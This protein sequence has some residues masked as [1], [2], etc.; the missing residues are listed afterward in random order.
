MNSRTSFDRG[1]WL[2]DSFAMLRRPAKQ[3]RTI[4]ATARYSG[5]GQV[6]DVGGGTG[7]IA[8]YFAEHGSAVTVLD[9]SPEML[10][11]AQARSLD[12]Q[13]G[14]AQDI[15]FA[16]E[17]FELVYSVDA[18]HH[19]T[20]GYESADH[21]QTID[22]CIRELLRV[23]KPNGT[24][25]LVEFNPEQWWGKTVEFLENR[26]CRLGSTF[27]SPSALRGIFAP[28]P[29]HIEITEGGS[30]TYLARIAKD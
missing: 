20:N 17:T 14:A 4:V 5:S 27:S 13:L 16:D 24:L 11:R 22:R 3:Y 10:K 15:P 28:Y 8:R 6:L 9:P 12:T 26:I 25:M 30:A 23:L 21:R 18:F 1:A 2:Y 19:F 7:L 29:L